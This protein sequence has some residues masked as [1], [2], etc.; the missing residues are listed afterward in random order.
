MAQPTAASHIMERIEFLTTFS[1]DSDKLTRTY[2]TPSHKAAGVQIGHWMSEAGMDV[3]TDSVGN[4]IGRY[5]GQSRNLP[6]LLTGSHFDTVR[7]AGKYDGMYG[8]L[9]AI[10]AVS[11]LNENNERLPFAIEVIGFADEEGTRFGATLLGSKGVA[12]TF[13]DTLLELVDV[14]GVALSAAM[15][16]YGLDPA[17]VSQAAC[18]PE[19]YLGYVELHIEQGPI[20]IDQDLPVGIVTAIAGASRFSVTV[21]GLASHA[22]TVPMN[23]RNDALLAAAEASLAIERLSLDKQETVGTVGQLTVIDGATNVIPGKVEFSVD[24]RCGNDA[25]RQSLVDAM[26]QAFSSI[27]QKRG[28]SFETTLTHEAPAVQCSDQLISQLANAVSRKG[29]TPLQLL[30]GAGHDAMALGAF[31]PVSML[32][33]RCGN[34]GISHHP[35][36]TMTE[37]DAIAGAEVLLDFIR[38]FDTPAS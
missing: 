9:A 5:E 18:S 11:E 17:K 13:E 21:D 8:V 34:G 14:E 36:E 31:T 28:V 19:N 20:L 23:L 2:L 27:E 4:V 30:S 37:S 22:G 10:A 38:H 3:R 1:E 26:E 35:D 29:Y 25:T 15:I 12:G 33:V 24:L 16:D 6:A 7:N 32:F